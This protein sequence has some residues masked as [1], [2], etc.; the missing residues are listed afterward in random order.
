MNVSNNVITYTAPVKQDIPRQTS[1]KEEFKK[2]LDEHELQSK[3]STNENVDKTNTKE[4]N[5]DKTEIKNSDKVTNENLSEDA[6]KTIVEDDTVNDLE[7]AN[8]SDNVSNEITNVIKK[9]ID[10]LKQNLKQSLKGSTEVDNS[11]VSTEIINNIKTIIDNLKQ[12]INKTSK[13]LI[14]NDKSTGGMDQ[15]QQL[16]QS[17]SSMLQSINKTSITKTSE[18]EINSNNLEKLVGGKLTSDSNGMLKN[19]LSEIVSLLEKSKGNSEVSTKILENLQKLTDQ[20]KELQ[21]DLTSLKVPIPQTVSETSEDKSIKDNLI[22]MVKNQ[23]TKTTSEI[24]PK[25]QMQNSSDSK[26]DNKSSGNSATDE[27]FLKNLISGDKDDTKIS[28]VV[29]FM[30][31]FQTVKTSDTTKV[32]NINLVINKNNLEVDVI[33]SVKF[34]ELN[35]IKDLT[36]KMNP[37]E[38]GEITIKLTM[39]SGIMKASISAQNKDTYALL[40]HNIQDI[41]DRLKNMDIKIQSLD[42]SVY[43]DSTFFSKDSSAKNNNSEQNN[44]SKTNNDSEEDDISIR[45]N[46][47]IEDNQVNKFV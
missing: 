21:T 18:I 47:V 28:K 38:L 7:N 4:E 15:I 30:N 9:I 8:P 42:I 36:V 5:P 1:G 6:K 27:K 3:N 39:E 20:V 13:G 10:L 33:K 12:N 40:N 2:A 19:N 16:L 31:Q 11:K 34:M 23:S 14:D 32:Q 35:N 41:S 24:V 45:N 25:N 22:K 37:K 26:K 17:L 44:N 46:Y 43:E 29:S